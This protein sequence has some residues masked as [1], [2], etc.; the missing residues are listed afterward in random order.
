MR[1]GIAYNAIDCFQLASQRTPVVIG[2]RLRVLWAAILAGI[3]VI[4]FAR[5]ADSGD[6]PL[7]G[8][9]PLTKASGGVSSGRAAGNL[10]AA[11]RAVEMGI[12]TV[13]I[14]LYEEALNAP[15]ADRAAI[16]LPLATAMLSAGRAADAEK[17]LQTYPGSRG[18]EWRLRVGLAAAQQRRYDVARSE[19]DK[20]N[21]DDL[22][23]PDRAWFW[24]LQ[25]VLAD[26]LVPRDVAKAN[27]FYVLAER[28]APSDM[29]RATFLIAGARLR[30][31]Y[32]SYSAADIEGQRKI[33]E[34]HQ[35]SSLGYGAAEQ[36]AV[37]RDAT[38]ASNEAVR[39][40]EGVILRLPRAERAWLDRL[41]RLLGMIGDRRRG[42]AG[43][44]ALN[45]LLETGTDSDYQRQA[46]QLLARDSEQEPERGLY[47]AELDKLLAGNPKSPIRDSI[48]L[49]RAELAL[50]DTPKDYATAERR[51][52]ELKDSFPGSS[53]R[54]HAF[55][56]LA[57]SAWEQHRYRLAADNAR[58]ARE[59]LAASPAAT[60][61]R[62]AKVVAQTIA[63]LR[64]MEAEARFR[65]QDYRLAADAYAAAL[66]DAPAGIPPG[67]LMFQRALASI[68]ADSADPKADLEKIVDELAA[69]RRFDPENRWEA[70]WSLARGLRLQGRVDAAL[71]RISR[72]MASQVESNAIKPDLLARMA[73][74]QARL[75]YEAN[76]PELTLQLVPNLEARAAAVPEAMRIEIN[77]T[78][79]LLKAQAEFKLDREAAGLETLEKL[80]TNFPKTEAAINSYLVTAAYYA[81]PG[82]D[83]IQD[84]QN[85]L[86]KLIDHPDYKDS[87][88]VP[89]ALFELAMLSER[90]GQPKDL[91]DANRR[92]EELV[93]PDRNPPAPP[94]LVFA[95]R[96]K[97]GDLLRT[98]NEFARAQVAYEDL[99][100]NP[101]YAQRP[102]VVVARLRLAECHNAQSSTDAS[103][104]HADQAQSLFEELLGLVSAPDDVRVEAGY[105]LGKLWERRGQSDKAAQVWWRDVIQPF[106]IDANP[107]EHAG[108][109]RP[110]WLARTLYDLGSL[111]EQ[112]EKIDEARRVYVLL[113]D[114]H[115]GWEG[116]AAERLV[117]LGVTVK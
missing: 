82:R 104:T 73:W 69:D 78:A 46:L 17:L 27:N 1:E 16:A 88:Y 103:G 86:R 116:I 41:R 13:A 110:Y 90:L 39:F 61:E 112:R 59:A 54:A 36:H 58:Q 55:V 74:L 38:G 81:A 94:E 64:V 49:M 26:T 106:L 48:L 67:D 14:G 72:V 51:A 108:A 24:F 12:P 66:R 91:E 35:D 71:E 111:Y 9:V 5:A 18:P 42:G 28:E 43:R 115:L 68:R 83:K 33:Y 37:M 2:K 29:A 75:S 31:R 79:A 10:V 105:N 98:L 97:Q 89:F 11:Q 47:R 22:L 99:V 6:E 23:R 60:A 21:V 53:L 15:G 80:R 109:T 3:A 19:V 100:N 4:P 45:L 25:A 92:I 93:S 102:D 56:V 62:E 95:A 20:I 65:A 40:L 70:E 96:L 44:N 63:E 117:H 7:N 114:S 57:T 84:S 76:K 52:A 113:R 107:A 87:L 32:V 30:L 85:W 101:K 77:S 50:T 8:P 34:S